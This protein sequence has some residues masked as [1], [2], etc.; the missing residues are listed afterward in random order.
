MGFSA[1]LQPRVRA[2]T[3]EAIAFADL[4]ASAEAYDLLRLVI[5]T[6]KDQVE[7]HELE[8]RAKPARAPTPRRSRGSRNSSSRPDGVA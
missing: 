4:R 3:Y 2:R 6:R 1:G 8:L 7:R 5:E